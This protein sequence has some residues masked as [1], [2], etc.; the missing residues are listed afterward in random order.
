[1]HRTGSAGNAAAVRAE[2]PAIEAILSDCLVY[3]PQSTYS[4]F[5]L[6]WGGVLFESGS[7]VRSGWTFSG[8]SGGWVAGF[9]AVADYVQQVRG[10]GG[11]YSQ[12]V[13]E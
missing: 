2:F 1:M 13:S 11:R 4:V 8:V 6:L 5:G 12:I 3:P 7:L 9:K 10:V